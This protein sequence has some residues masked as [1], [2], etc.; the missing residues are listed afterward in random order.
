M[1][2]SFSFLERRLRDKPFLKG[3]CQGPD[4][5]YPNEDVEHQLVGSNGEEEEEVVKHGLRIAKPKAQPQVHQACMIGWHDRV[6]M[7]RS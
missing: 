1:N 3:G 2:S 4:G 5:A 6:A 7:E